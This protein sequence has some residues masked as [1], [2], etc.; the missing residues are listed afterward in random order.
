[1]AVKWKYI[2]IKYC[3]KHNRLV[4]LSLLACAFCQ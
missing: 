3:E 4:M 1:M 2:W